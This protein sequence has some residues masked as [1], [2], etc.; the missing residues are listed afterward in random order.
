M[1]EMTTYRVRPLVNAWKVEA[2]RKDIP[3]SQWPSK[4]DAMHAA[5][6]HACG[7]VR[8]VVVL[9]ESGKVESVF[10]PANVDV[11]GA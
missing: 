10:P 7:E 9:D 1:L 4:E 2:D 11:D 3:S 8:K 6:A 5:H